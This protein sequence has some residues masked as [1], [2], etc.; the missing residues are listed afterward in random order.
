MRIRMKFGKPKLSDGLQSTTMILTN[1][2]SFIGD[3]ESS[4]FVDFETWEGDEIE[5]EKTGPWKKY[6]FCYVQELEAQEREEKAAE[7][8]KMQMK[9][10]FF[11]KLGVGE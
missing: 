8:A 9:R 1:E 11:K 6:R 4:G 10:S 3:I 2:V 7:E 5:V